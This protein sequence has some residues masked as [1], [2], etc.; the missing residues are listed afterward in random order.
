MRTAITLVLS[1]LLA[2]AAG[3]DLIIPQASSPQILIPVAGDAQG[4][5]GTHFRTDLSIVNFRS[6]E[7]RV[8]VR[9]MPADRSGESVPLRTIT[10]NAR[11]GFSSNDFV[12][13]VLG[14]TGLGGI[15]MTAVNANGQ[16]DPDGQLHATVRIWTPQP[17]VANG[18]M[19]QTFPA[20]IPTA[21][22]FPVKWIFGA[23][24]S[25]QYRLNIGVVN[26]DSVAAMYRVSI[27]N[28]QGA[29]ESRD[30]T[31]QPFSIHQEGFPGTLDTIQ[32]IVERLNPTTNSAWQTWASSVDNVT[33]D[34]WS[35]MGFVAPATSPQPVSQQEQP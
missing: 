1:L 6:V 19:S 32:V 23:R 10:V 12:G 27:I 4:A 15:L 8:A 25:E 22:G 30:Y 18:T 34:A 33:G 11:S 29:R 21:T 9:W 3:A 7:Q 20:I 24:R 28:S 16:F 31:L 26:P 2:S 35:Q 13:T 5:N 17:N 14:Q